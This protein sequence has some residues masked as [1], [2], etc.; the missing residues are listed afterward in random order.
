M[1]S[2]FMGLMI[3]GIIVSTFSIFLVLQQV[4]VTER[5]KA[6][7]LSLYALLRMS[8][9]KKVYDKCDAY[10]DSLMVQGRNES[11]QV[12]EEL[13]NSVP[14]GNNQGNELVVE[15]SDLSEEEKEEQMFHVQLQA[16]Q[17]LRLK[18]AM[19]LANRKAIRSNFAGQAR[20]SAMIK[21][22]VG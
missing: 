19:K 8:E 22:T 1:N 5:K 12:A 20:Y 4:W 14:A 17:S 10:L 3:A 9:I 11:D 15:D 16:K 2:T 13:A 18:N 7:T 6:D 21:K